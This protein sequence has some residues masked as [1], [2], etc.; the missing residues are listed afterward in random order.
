[1][2][3]VR[4]FGLVFVETIYC[5]TSSSELRPHIPARIITLITISWF[6]HLLW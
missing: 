4:T 5:F 3:R 1:M 6:L 2:D